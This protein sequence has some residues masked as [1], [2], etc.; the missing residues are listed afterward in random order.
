VPGLGFRERRGDRVLLDTDLLELQRDVGRRLPRRAELLVRSLGSLREL[1]PAR[2]LRLDLG[3]RG[4]Q[5][6]LELFVRARHLLQ[7]R[8]GSL[9]L[10]LDLGELVLQGLDLGP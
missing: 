6:A 3:A 2:E 5:L 8:L 4:G 10:P 9:S 1:D 7:L